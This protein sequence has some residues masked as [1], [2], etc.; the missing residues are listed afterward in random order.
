MEKIT[1][2]PKKYTRISIRKRKKQPPVINDH[3]DLYKIRIKAISIE[4]EE[5]NHPEIEIYH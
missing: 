5:S 3:Q 1:R 2:V 4:A